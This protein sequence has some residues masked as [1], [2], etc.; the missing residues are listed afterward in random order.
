MNPM[1]T[2]RLFEQDSCGEKNDGKLAMIRNVCKKHARG[3]QMSLR[4]LL[5]TTRKRGSHKRHPSRLLPFSHSF[6]PCQRLLRK[7]SLTPAVLQDSPICCRIR[8]V[9]T[10]KR[11]RTNSYV[12]CCLHWWW[13]VITNSY[14]VCSM[15]YWKVQSP[16]KGVDIQVWL[17]IDTWTSVWIFL[18]TTSRLFQMHSKNLPKRNSWTVII[19]SCVK[20]AVKNSKWARVCGWRQHHPFSFV[21]S[22]DL[23]LINTDDYDVFTSMFKFPSDWKLET[24][25]PRST[26]LL[27]R[28]TS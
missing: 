25:C 13:T 15:A 28:H 18:T 6:P 24:T 12:L 14:Q 16:F 21:I 5:K 7:K 9:L 22:S 1:T 19:K 20:S 4:V 17:E 3:W 11:M 26:R 8:C 27:H 2:S 23:R 10:N